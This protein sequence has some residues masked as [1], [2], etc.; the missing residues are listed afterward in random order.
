MNTRRAVS[1]A[2]AVAAAA[3]LATGSL[4]FSSVSAERGVQVNVVD[5]EDAFVNATVCRVDNGNG[6]K[7]RVQVTNQYSSQFTVDT[8][9]TDLGREL[10]PGQRSVELSPGESETFQGKLKANNEVTVV[11]SGKL[12]AT[13]KVEIGSP[14]CPIK[15]S[16]GAE[17]SDHGQGANGAQGNGSNS[18]GAA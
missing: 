12:T 1:I 14:N 2:L 15:G 4:G 10:P 7:V 16:S 11:V 5:T 9:T 17:E 13:V 8:I 6:D 18:K 3:M